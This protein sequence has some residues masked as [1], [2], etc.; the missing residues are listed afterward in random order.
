[1]EVST[2]AVARRRKMVIHLMKQFLR[3]KPAALLWPWRL[4]HHGS[5][6]S[7]VAFA[8]STPA[9]P[10]VKSIINYPATIFSGKARSF[11]QAWYNAYPWLED[12][13]QANACF[14]YSCCLFGSGPASKWNRS[15]TVVGFW[16]WKCATGKSGVLF[17]HKSSFTHRQS[18]Q[19]KLNLLHKTTISDQLRLCWNK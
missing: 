14:C 19:Y 9:S 8:V 17:K 13:V 4:R 5:P 6:D 10:P 12:S 11:S 3:P 15:F 2:A 18:M 16:D 7:P 1:M